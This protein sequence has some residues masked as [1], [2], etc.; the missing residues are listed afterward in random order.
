MNP[1]EDYILDYPKE[2]IRQLMQLTHQLLLDSIPQIQCDIKW[3]I[4][5]Y[6]YKKPFCFLNP[7]TKYLILG[8]MN[9]QLLSD[10]HQLLEGEQKIL[11]HY[12]IRTVEDIYREEFLEL[13][14]EAVMLNES[15]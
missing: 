8:L 13:L 7:K 2:D 15:S 9:G 10:S 1:V 11:R 3:K 5:F 14:M 12:I 4:P 6:T